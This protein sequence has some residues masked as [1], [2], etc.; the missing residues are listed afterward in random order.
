MKEESF[1][2]PFSKAMLTSVF[3]GF[4]TC[5][6]CLIFNIIYRDETGFPLNDII[7]VST[8]I[9]AVNLL[10]VVIGFIYFP[11]MNSSKKS[12]MIFV[13]IFLLLT[14]LGVIKAESVIRSSDHELTQ[15]FRGLLLGII[16]ITG[17]GIL[18]IPLLFHNR[19]FR[20]TIL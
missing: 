1:Q 2:T 20:E 3:V 10:F 9:F 13:V 17:L 12:E 15:Q 5:I 14:I 7:N 11:F 8:L 16:I 4:V 18:S 19:K 6:V